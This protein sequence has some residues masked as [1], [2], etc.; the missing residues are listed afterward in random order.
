M[1]RKGHIS[2][3]EIDNFFSVFAMDNVSIF[4]SGLERAN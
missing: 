2:I 4:K 3:T 1:A